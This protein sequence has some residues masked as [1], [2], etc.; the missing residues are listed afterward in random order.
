MVE[1]AVSADDSGLSP[2]TI[3]FLVS[4]GASIRVDR[5]VANDEPRLITLLKAIE[6]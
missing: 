5:A 6:S 2:T 3:P 4:D 1:C